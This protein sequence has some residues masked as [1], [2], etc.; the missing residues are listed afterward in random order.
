[1]LICNAKLL[2]NHHEEVINDLMREEHTRTVEW[3]GDAENQM[4][5]ILTGA[6]GG[7]R[8][9]IVLRNCSRSSILDD[10]HEMVERPVAGYC[11]CC[12]WL[13]ASTTPKS[14]VSPLRMLSQI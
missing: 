3:R 14:K 10:S 11:H 5:S 8:K 2:K 1:M 4:D 13:Y 9:V 12:I 6:N 7:S